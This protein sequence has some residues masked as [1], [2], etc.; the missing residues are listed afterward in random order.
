MNVERIRVIIGKE[1]M[2][3]G[4]NK[5]VLIMMALLPVLL[6]GMILVTTYF[7]ARVPETDF[8]PGAG[9][10]LTLPPQMA[11]LDPKTG[12]IVLM[13]DQYMFY[14][15]LIPM[16]LPVYMAAYSIIGEKE[17]RSLEPLLA[18]PISTAELLVGK[19]IAAV[20]PAVIL[21]WLSFLLTAVG[22]YAIASP[23]VFEYLVRPVWTLS[24]A[25]QAP[26]FALLSTSSGVIAS[27]RMNDPRAA[28]QVTGLF[29]VP[30][31]GLSMLVLMG[32][33]YLSLDLLIWATV[34]MVAVNVGVLWLA[35]KLFR[36]ETILTRW[37]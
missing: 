23:V 25:I 20:T 16:A 10:A 11:H 8:E 6:V 32:R 7:M 4:K 13:N 21:A 19:T 24:M 30:V 3:M 27:S 34:A 33:L 15:L 22:M 37:K 17:A 12:A 18:T 36:R 35:V 31:I 28:Q 14:L 26:L 2:D 29:V 9:S 1:W 5:M